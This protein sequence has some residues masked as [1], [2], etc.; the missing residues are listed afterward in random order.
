M[1]V[2][3]LIVV[4][5]L[6]DLVE[7]VGNERIAETTAVARYDAVARGDGDDAEA[8]VEAAPCSRRGTAGTDTFGL[9]H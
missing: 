7:F 6:A 9:H 4:V 5:V 2:D 8:E 1:T 3:Y